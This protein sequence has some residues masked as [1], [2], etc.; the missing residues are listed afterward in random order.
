M[1]SRGGDLLNGIG[2]FR[3]LR[4]GSLSYYYASLSRVVMVVSWLDV[5]VVFMKSG[6]DFDECGQSLGT[7]EC[8]W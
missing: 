3:K 2:G 6:Q 4:L 8:K 5:I 7:V 1:S